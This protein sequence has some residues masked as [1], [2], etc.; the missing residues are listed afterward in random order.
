[1]QPVQLIVILADKIMSLF[2]LKFWAFTFGLSSVRFLFYFFSKVYMGRELEE[3]DYM[4]IPFAVICAFLSFQL[5]RQ[6][7]KRRALLKK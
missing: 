4:V 3:A 1:M 6:L 7:K 2:W 5:L